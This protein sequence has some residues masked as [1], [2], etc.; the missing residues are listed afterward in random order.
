M[1]DPRNP[2][3]QTDFFTSV[4]L[5]PP[6]PVQCLLRELSKWEGESFFFSNPDLYWPGGASAPKCSGP[7]FLFSRVMTGQ[8]FP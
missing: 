1:A 2:C 7:G 6:L 5:L 3:S 4:N 8:V